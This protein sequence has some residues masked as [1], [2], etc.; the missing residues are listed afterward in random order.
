MKYQTPYD[1]FHEEAYLRHNQCRFN[2]LD[3]LNICFENKTILEV[4]AGIGDHTIYLLR[5]NPS[6]ILSLEARKD[7]YEILYGR[8]VRENKVETKLFN[9][10]KPTKLSENYDIC[11]CYGLL[12]HLEKPAV[13]IQF[14]A[15]HTNEILLLETCVDYRKEHTIN[16]LKEEASAYSQSYSGTG[17]RP[18]RIWIHNELKKHFR[19]VYM[20]TSQP[21]HEQFPIN[22]TSEVPP[23]GLTRSIYVASNYLINNSS[24]SNELIYKQENV[25]KISK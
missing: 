6:K 19:Y 17:C 18:G 7:N 11:Y 5:K 24:L 12:Y 20:P 21:D 23:H 1:D 4:G 9:M 22:W 2:H 25:R 16:L 14:M 13:A 8:Y 10:D 3:S 15:E